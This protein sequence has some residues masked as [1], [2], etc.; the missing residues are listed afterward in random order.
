ML[1]VENLSDYVKKFLNE[2]GYPLEMRVARAFKRAGFHV[3][4]ARTY[5]DLDTGVLREMDVLAR[6]RQATSASASVE[7]RMV[8]ECKHSEKSKP[9]LL[10]VGDTRF[11]RSHEHFNS[12]DIIGESDLRLAEARAADDLPIISH[13][14]NIAYRVGTA[15]P[16]DDA[17]S[18]VRQVNGAVVGIKDDLAGPSDLTEDPVVVVVVPVIVTDAPLFECRLDEA[19]EVTATP[20]D[21]GLLLARLRAEDRLHSVWIVNSSGIDAFVRLARTT[22]DAMWLTRRR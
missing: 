4:Q 17:F 2:S 5:I 13:V 10:F 12:L 8:I 9:W 18:A 6:K 20:V 19:N 14:G 16:R 22:V 11:Y 15:G 21:K 7:L 3:E 1:Q